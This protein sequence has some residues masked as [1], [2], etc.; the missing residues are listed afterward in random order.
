VEYAE[1]SVESDPD[2]GFE[3]FNAKVQLRWGDEDSL[4]HVNNVIHLR[5]LEE[6]RVRFLARVGYIGDVDFGM[7]TARH[8]IDYVR[9]LHYSLEPVVIR[10]WLSR[11]GNA[12]FTIRCQTLNRSDEVVVDAATVIVVTTLDG[13]SSQPMGE[14]ARNSLL[15]FLRAAT[16]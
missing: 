2:E 7:V 13:S 14:A 11:V 5:L 15:P 16:S 9:P 3:Y 1:G 12:A 8:E 10:C 6:A 4:G